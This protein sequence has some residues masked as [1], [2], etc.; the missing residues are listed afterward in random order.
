MTDLP[1]KLEAAKGPPLSAADPSPVTLCLSERQEQIL[2]AVCRDFIVSGEP[3]ASAALVR[4]HGFRWSSATLRQELA[5]LE[6]LGLLWRPHRSA[7]C[8][9]TEVGLRCYVTLLPAS[10]AEPKLLDAVDRSLQRVREDPSRSMRAAVCVLSE[11]SGCL[12]VSFL[13]TAQ[14][15]RM[16]QVDVVP[17]V[18]SRG[19]VVLTLEGG[20]THVQ[21]IELESSHELAG[22]AASDPSSELLGLQERLRR[23]CVG[24]TL[25]DAREA[26]LRR[27]GEH[28]AQ[29]DRLLAQA[30]RVGLTLCSVGPLDPLWM[31]I[32]GQPSLAR[33]LADSE[34]LGDVLALLEDDQRLA[35]VLDQLLPA[36]GDDPRARVH[37]GVVGVTGMAELAGLGSAWSDGPEPGLCLVGCRVPM[38]GGGG[39]AGSDR[40]PDRGAVAL[41]GSARM[42]YAAMIPLVE[43]AA[44]A[45]AARMCA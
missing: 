16:E 36:D 40:G 31:Q 9:P 20:A 43:Y 44:R 13:G 35:E 29:I 45:L 15:G 23:L 22:R 32:A 4:R 2:R 14:G 30:L 7:G 34:R 21:P 24:R 39:G 26:L 6:R 1:P 17:L 8:S 18:G 12:A 38:P 27:L 5:A 28:E 41:L 37:V 19:L 25:P 3:V 42:D 33:G 10:R 11:A